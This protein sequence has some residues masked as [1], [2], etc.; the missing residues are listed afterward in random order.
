MADAMTIDNMDL[1]KD[2]Q[3][4]ADFMQKTG[5]LDLE[6]VEEKQE[7]KPEPTTEEPPKPAKI[8]VGAEEFTEEELAEKLEIAKNPSAFVRKATFETQQVSNARK[9]IERER[10]SIAN[11]RAKLDTQLRE[12]KGSSLGDPAIEKTVQALEMLSTKLNSVEQKLNQRDEAIENQQVMAREMAAIEAVK[13]MYNDAVEFYKD[14][15]DVKIPKPGTKDFDSW[16]LRGQQINPLKVVAFEQ[17]EKQ[18]LKS[19]KPAPK[20]DGIESKPPQTED[21]NGLT[22]DQLEV[23]R[24]MGV[25][26]QAMKTVARQMGK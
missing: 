6:P 24:M 26:A 13:T 11:E 19:G 16:A 5:E 4:N 1:T 25:S 15:P 18:I 7:V 10:E 17:Y 21:T 3:T 20:L 23:G 14:Y 8:K 12:I 2:Q 9:E 22:A